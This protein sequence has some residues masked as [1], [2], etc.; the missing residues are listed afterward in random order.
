VLVLDLRIFTLDLPT[1]YSFD[2]ERVFLCNRPESGTSKSMVFGSE[3][4]IQMSD[5]QMKSITPSALRFPA[6]VILVALVCL[7]LGLGTAFGQYGQSQSGPDQ[8]G[9]GSGM[10]GHTGRHQMPSVDDQVKHM[11]KKLNLSDDQQAKLKPI[12][13]DQ[14]KQM[15]QIRDDSSL[16]REDRF[17]KMKSVHENSASQIKALLNDDQQKKFDK[18][19]AERREHMGDRGPGNGSPPSDSPRQQQ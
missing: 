2:D 3:L 1:L 18:M 4:E 16:S 13:E 6:A 7:S 12:L 5:S 10:E 15:E 9:Q 8:A 19:Q 11:A 17:S 14:R